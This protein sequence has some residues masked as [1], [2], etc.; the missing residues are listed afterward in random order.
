MADLGILTTR[1]DYHF[2]DEGL[3]DEALSH[4]SSGSHN[5]ERME[6]LG[7]SFLNFVIAQELYKRRPT[8][9]EGALS[10][11]R[12]SLVRQSTLADIARELNLGDYLKLGIG[13]LRSGGFRRDSILSDVV[14]SI[15]G[16]VLL[17][18]GHDTART[19]VLRLYGDRIDTLPPSAELKDPKTRLQELLQGRSYSRPEYEVIDASGKSHDM[20]FTVACT[21][22]EL[23]LKVRATATS[24]RKAEQAAAALMLEDLHQQLSAQSG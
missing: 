18:A 14:E 12:A 24:R 17:D 10:R 16:A 11:L 21:L 13:E 20:R 23:S 2:S 6:F 7:D 1:L 3:L 5:Y 19:L 22:P 9:D 4:R 8:E 15:I